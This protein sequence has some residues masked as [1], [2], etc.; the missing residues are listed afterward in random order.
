MTK[1]IDSE[2]IGFFQIPIRHF[3]VFSAFAADQAV[4]LIPITPNRKLA[5]EVKSL[6]AL[7]LTPMTI[8]TRKHSS[9]ITSVSS[10]SFVRY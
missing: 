3:R 9:S 7:W 4:C 8:G 1:S 6:M 10:V 2:H 5:S